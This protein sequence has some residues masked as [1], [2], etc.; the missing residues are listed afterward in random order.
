MSPAYRL[1]NPLTPSVP[2]EDGAAASLPYE[3]A[4]ALGRSLR[5]RYAQ[6]RDPEFPFPDNGYQGDYLLEIAGST[7]RLGGWSVDL[8][9]DQ[10]SWSDVVAEIHDMPHGYSPSMEEGISFYAPQW[11]DTIR[12][13]FTACA[14]RGEPYDEELEIVTAH[15]EHRWVR[16]VGEAVRDERGD[17][18]RVE[19]AFQD[20]SARHE[21]LARLREQEQTLRA[22]RDELARVLETRQALINSLPAHIAL[23]DGHGEVIDVNEQWR[24]FAT[25]NAIRDA[26]F[27]VGTNY[28]AICENAIGECAEG[29]QEAA[30]GLRALLAGERESFTLEYPCHSPTEYRWFRV[31]ANALSMEEVADTSVGAV[32]MHVDITERKLAEQ[33]LNRLAYQD[34]LTGLPSRSGFLQRVTERLDKASQPLG[35]LMVALN[36]RGLH[37][38][39]EAHGFDAGDELLISLGARLEACSGEGGVVGRAG[40]DDFLVFLPDVPGAQQ[41]R[42]EELNV[43][44]SEPFDLG[45]AQLEVAARFGYTGVEPGRRDVDKM[46]RE[47]SLALSHTRH[48]YNSISA[49]GY[50]RAQEEQARERIRTNRELHRALENRE[51]ELHFQPQ[52]ELA[53]GRLIPSEALLR[54][55]HPQRGLVPPGAFIS[56]AEQS[57]LIAPIGDWVIDEACRHLRQWRDAG[58]QAV[59]V[60][61]N[62]SLVQFMIGDFIET[63]REAL[64]RYAVEPASLSLEITESVFEQQSEELLAQ[65]RELHELGIRL[66]LDDFGT[67]YSSLLYLQRYPFDEIKIDRGFVHGLLTDTYSRHIVTTVVGMG[68]AID[69]EVLAEGIET[70]QVRD[71]LLEMDCRLG[72]G[73]YFSLPLEAEDYR[74]LLEQGPRLPLRATANGR[75]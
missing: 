35:G 50:T 3:R 16:T 4:L 30:E 63:V 66:S 73:F 25:E 34:L 11:R 38:V 52:V 41:R 23:L 42:V 18:V 2:D 69:A 40:G 62:V 49:T 27:G 17:I 8:T 59:R 31:M 58:L 10:I 26:Q 32:V 53:S 61:V 6:L 54:W 13:R 51:F 36:I 19:G 70:A 15:G 28:I 22:S 20:I 74:W 45:H 39:N 68:A 48:S 47:S 72:Q 65:M 29:A 7:A 64:D 24:H 12:A 56:H 44:F 14:E 5:A 60:S 37:D 33:E 46:L 75:V 55:R 71:S 57:Q 67:G 1:G 43:A 21:M 9:S